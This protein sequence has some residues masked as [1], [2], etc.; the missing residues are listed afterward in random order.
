MNTRLNLLFAVLLLATLTSCRHRE[1]ALPEESYIAFVQE[2]ITNAY[3]ENPDPELFTAAF[4]LSEFAGRIMAQGDIPKSRRNDLERF[5]QDYFQPGIR[6]QARIG[7]GADFQ[8]VSFR[9][10]HDTASALFRIYNGAIT[11]EEWLMT[12]SG[13]KISI[14]D[15]TDPISGMF[16]SDEW[17]MNACSFLGISSDHFLINE[18]LIA[19]NQAVG[20]KDFRVADSIFSWVEQATKTNPYAQALRLNLISQSQSYDS[21]QNACRH[22]LQIFPGR[23]ATTDF[24]CLQNAISHGMMPEVRRHCDAL[25]QHLGYDPIFFLYLAWGYKAA[26]DLD[27]SL[28]MLDSLT[29]YMPL[30]YDFYN[31]K[32]DIFYDLHDTPGFIMQMDRIDSLFSAS[33]EDIPFYENSYPEMR[34]TP[35]FKAWKERHL[36]KLS[37]EKAAL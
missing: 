30:Q 27:A 14:I 23:K 24:F 15:I 5:L 9:M 21:L 2:I 8:L 13:K 37:N 4:D 26:G 35:E 31:Y 16:W 10:R 19:V 29:T 18:K 32:L 22:F 25:G 11:F 34:N 20:R 36:H 3:S 1:K 17:N 7:D 12:A 33:D 28:R 6:M